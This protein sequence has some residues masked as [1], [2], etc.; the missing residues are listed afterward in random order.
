MP[1][2]LNTL[3]LV[4]CLLC[5]RSVPALSQT[6]QAENLTGY[7]K[8]YV[9]VEDLNDDARNAGLSVQ[10]IKT[11]VELELRRSGITVDTNA[12]QPVYVAIRLLELPSGF[13]FSINLEVQDR[14]MS[15]DGAMA[16]TRTATGQIRDSIGTNEIALAYR[17]SVKIAT[18]W[19]RKTL[20]FTPSNGARSYI[21]G[22]L[23]DLL[24][25]LLNDYLAVD[26]K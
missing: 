1:R 18:I 13:A 22:A 2:L 6:F 24:Y 26:P 20:G 5:M 11:K 4:L 19:D 7:T 16:L 8:F 14:L 15:F 21:M 10:N 25:V 12:I 23:Q 3:L 17:G 9:I